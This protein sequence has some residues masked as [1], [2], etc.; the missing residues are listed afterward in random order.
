MLFHMTNSSQT[1]VFEKY[2]D[3]LITVTKTLVRK[4]CCLGPRPD[5]QIWKS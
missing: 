3:Q 5:T 2:G 4:A 1:A